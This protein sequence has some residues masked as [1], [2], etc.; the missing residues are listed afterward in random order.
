MGMTMSD[1]SEFTQRADEAIVNSVKLFQM[2]E[3]AHCLVVYDDN[4]ESGISHQERE[5]LI[6]GLKTMMRRCGHAAGEEI[7]AP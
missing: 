5:D 6:S 2:I 7:P 4:T 3:M 1:R